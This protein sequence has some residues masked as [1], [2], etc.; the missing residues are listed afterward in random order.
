MTQRIGCYNLDAACATLGLNRLSGCTSDDSLEQV[1]HWNHAVHATGTKPFEV[2][3]D[4][5]E[6]K[7]AK[8]RN[9]FAT[10]FQLNQ[11]RQ[12]I[13]RD[14]NASEVSFVVANCAEY[15]G[16]A[17]EATAP[18]GLSFE[19]AQGWGLRHRQPG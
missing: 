10:E 5:L 7:R 14:F 3:R 6:S 8:R 17:G 15:A 19:P 9:Q 16:L 11:A 1:F 2:K 13:W 4:E 12:V 18:P